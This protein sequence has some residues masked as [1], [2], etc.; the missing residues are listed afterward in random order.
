MLVT[1]R[2]PREELWLALKDRRDDWAASGIRSAQ[3]IGDCHAPATIAHAVHAGHRFGRE[4]DEPERG[5]ELPFRR[6][7][8]QL[9]AEF[10][11]S[12]P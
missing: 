10:P 4:L 9:S 3:P 1:A 7:L 8:S 11:V 12:F 5:D 2:L 6:E